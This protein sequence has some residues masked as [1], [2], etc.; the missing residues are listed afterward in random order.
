MRVNNTVFS[1]ILKIFPRYKF[2]RIVR[3]IG[4]D[5][6]YKTFKSWN[7]FVAMLFSQFSGRKSLRDIVDSFNSHASSFYHLGC[8]HK[9][10]RSTLAD[11]NNKRNARLFEEI[12][13]NLLPLVNRKTFRESTSVIQALDATLINLNK[14]KFGW[15]LG[16]KS[17]GGI[18]I[19]TVYD[20]NE[21]IPTFF[22][23]AHART[24]DIEVA[25]TRLQLIP[26][27][28][29]VF[30]KG[31]YCFTWW[32]RLD[33]AGCRFVTRLKKHTLVDIVE[34]KK[35]TGHEVLSDQI[36]SLTSKREREGGVRKKPNPYTKPLRKIE[37]KREGKEPLVIISNDLKSSAEEISLLYKKRWQIELFFKWI[38]QN[39]K[40]KSFLGRTKNAV[41]TQVAIA[42]IS[43][44]L[45][46]ILQCK[47]NLSRSLQS[48]FRL[49]QTNLM[50]LKVL[51]DVLYPPPENIKNGDIQL[52]L[53]W[54]KC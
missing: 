33:E 3:K 28:T 42:M 45:I 19:H 30:D 43:Y 35:V 20:I 8:S 21:Q 4:S 32:A 50:H 23:I 54:T 22:E 48:L 51:I 10:K 9:I 44:L 17:V 25:K 38:K 47:N 27:S 14:I 2:E 40:I 37:I 18:K 1:Q 34:D 36:V 15:A 6:R 29:Y 49:I 52:S 11:A 39:L 5:Y 26:E 46:K 31:Y 7:H 41:K 16:M 12:F 13:K 53:E 24:N